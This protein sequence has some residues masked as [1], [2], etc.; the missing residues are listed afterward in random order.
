M[1]KLKTGII[2]HGGSIPVP[3]YLQK[4]TIELRDQRLLIQARGKPSHPVIDLAIPLEKLHRAAAE[5]R[6]Y[7][8]S[9]GYFLVLEYIDEKGEDA[10]LELEIRSFVRRGRAQALARYWA[11]SLTRERQADGD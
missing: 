11:E 1:K 2:Y 8:S 6:K 10:N 9:V 4:G 3:S 7:Y 5:E